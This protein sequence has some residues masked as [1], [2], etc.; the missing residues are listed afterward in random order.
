MDGTLIGQYLGEY[1]DLVKTFLPDITLGVKDIDKF[2]DLYHLTSHELSHASHFS[3]AGKAYWNKY[4]EYVLKSYVSSSGRIYGIGTETN[5]GYCEV[6]EMWAYYM[7]YACS[8]DRYGD[9]ATLT[10][11]SYWFSPQIF[12]Y[13]DERGLDRSRIFKSLTASVTNKDELQ[14]YL[15]SLYP[16]FDSIIEQAFDR[17]RSH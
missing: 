16:E 4:I 9:A 5:A 13:L 15:E 10:G 6:G 17:Y 8:R 2:S 1:S 14:T 7:G 12:L 3:Q 11:T